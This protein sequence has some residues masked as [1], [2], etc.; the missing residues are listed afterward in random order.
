MSID[1]HPT[2]S[3]ET[4]GPAET[5]CDV[6]GP[7]Q[8]GLREEPE[9]TQID[10]DRF[11]EWLDDGHDSHGKT[12]LEIRHRLVTYFDRRNR[13]F[14][15]DLAD[16]AFLRRIQN[17]VYVGTIEPELFDE[18]FNRV[19]EKMNLPCEPGSAEY[20]RELCR[21]RGPGELRACH[22]HDVLH[23]VASINAYE[24]RPMEITK[25]NLERA[26]RTYFTRTAQFKD[27]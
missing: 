3:F 19:L 12:Y 22:P 23:I 18:I 14:P 1:A 6:Y 21:T 7:T 4:R 20:L 10:F 25:A 24:D 16:E 26:T 11:L 13:P 5:E 17:K 9:L 15:D 2:C 8:G 27:Q